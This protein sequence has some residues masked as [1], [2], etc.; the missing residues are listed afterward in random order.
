MLPDITIVKEACPVLI[1]IGIEL[2]KENPNL[3][4]KIG[5]Q[6]GC[7]CFSDNSVGNIMTHI[8][9]EIIRH[10]ITWSKIIAI[11]A[12]AGGISV[13][14]VRQGKPEF[15]PIIHKVVANIVEKDLAIWIET[16]GGWVKKI[17]FYNFQIKK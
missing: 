6:I 4:I 5:R 11:Y 13:D 12:V 10:D 14:C 8:S 17:L 3:Y 2:E 16:S 7:G 9:R 15:L 1:A